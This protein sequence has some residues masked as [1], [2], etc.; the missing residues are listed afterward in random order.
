MPN[1]L[2]FGA[3]LLITCTPE[4]SE[5]FK[6]C[7]ELY[8]EME[9]YASSSKQ[10]RYPPYIEATAM[11]LREKLLGYL[12]ALVLPHGFADNLELPESGLTRLLFFFR[13][14]E[15]A[16][17]A[18]TVY[19]TE[20]RPSN[21]GFAWRQIGGF[22]EVDERRW[23]AASY[24]L[25]YGPRVAAEVDRLKVLKAMV[26]KNLDS[27]TLARRYLFSLESKCDIEKLLENILDGRRALFD[28]GS[29]S[30]REVVS[31]LEEVLGIRL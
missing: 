21:Q 1:F 20:S 11:D 2:I 7:D 15:G 23:R 13:Y 24:G 31:K 4:A 27:R 18:P 5:L 22:V 30:K 9:A 3:E 25:T 8:H 29:I 10:M 26:D 17:A 19:S 6:R 28:N 16:L 14:F 12:S